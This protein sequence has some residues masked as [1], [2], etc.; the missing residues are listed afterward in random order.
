MKEEWRVIEKFPDYE[1]SNYGRVRSKDRYRQYRHGLRLVKGQP[2]KV[3]PNPKRGNYVY[4]SLCDKSKHYSCKVHR[5]VAEAFIPNP[6]L[7][8]HVN[9]IDCDPQNNYVDNLEWVTPKENSDWLIACGHQAEPNARAL[10]ATDPMTGIQY[11][12]RSGKDAERKG[13]TRSAIWRCLVG[14]YATHHG[15]IWAYE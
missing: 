1:V 4:V 12:F 5:L 15:L 7:K 9:H 2:L 8:P 3:R 10:I 6:E 11:R 14:E 13:H